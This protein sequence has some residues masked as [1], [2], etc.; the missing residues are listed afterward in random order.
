MS[1]NNIN[2]PLSKSIEYDSVSCQVT[3]HESF[4]PLFNLLFTEVGIVY[5]E[6]HILFS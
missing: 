6:V 5:E 4:V 3:H 2:K 1:E